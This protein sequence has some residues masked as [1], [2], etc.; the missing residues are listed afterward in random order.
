[1][2]TPGLPELSNCQILK[3]FASE[4]TFLYLYNM[5]II[6]ALFSTYKHRDEK[7]VK[8]MSLSEGRERRSAQRWSWARRT[9]P[10]WAGWWGWRDPPTLPVLSPLVWTSNHIWLPYSAGDVNPDISQRVKK[11][12][13]TDIY[14]KMGKN[15]NSKKIFWSSIGKMYNITHVLLKNLII[16]IRDGWLRSRTLYFRFPISI[17]VEKAK[18]RLCRMRKNKMRLIRIFLHR[19]SSTGKI[20]TKKV[21]FY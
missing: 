9:S 20:S 11:K 18:G 21:F 10:W 13:S 19:Y 14:N 8:F 7:K 6:T 15:C 5:S 17:K 3:T 16:F 12:F 1:M 4:N 2:K